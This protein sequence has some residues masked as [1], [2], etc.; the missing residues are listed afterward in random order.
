MATVV[1]GGA[2]RSVSIG[3]VFS[4]GF[5]TIGS[6]PVLTLGIS[7]LFGALPSLAATTLLQSLSNQSLGIPGLAVIAAGLASMVIGIVFFAIT[8]GA[9]VRATVAHSQGRVAGFADS[10]MAGLRMIVPLFAAA[11]LSA[12]GMAFGFLLLFVPGI[13]LYCMWSVCAPAVVEERLGPIQAL[14]RSR[15]LTRGARWKIFGLTLVLVVSYW[16]FLAL[17]AVLGAAVYAGD[18]ASEAVVGDLSPRLL[19]INAV[20]Q[21]ISSAVWGVVLASLYVELREWKDGPA[22]DALA[23]VFG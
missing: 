14:A 7:F 9:L 5:G 4:R 12:I 23:D 13:I 20:V 6:N 17:V 19:A 16:L 11:I 15:Y 1:A 3:R 21:T 22:A 8:Q 10:T 2:D 18:P